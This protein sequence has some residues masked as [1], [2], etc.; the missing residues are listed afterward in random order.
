[1]DR[2]GFAHFEIDT[3]SET[4]LER[5]LSLIDLLAIGVG[6]TIG[7]GLFV[8]AGLV[9][10]EYAGPSSVVSWAI[11]G[12]AALLSGCCYA[13]LSARI[14]LSGGAYA[15]AF[16]AMGELPAVLT[17]ACLSLEYLAAASA[18]ARSWGDKVVEWLTEMLGD[19]HAAVNFLGSSS[20][21]FSPLAFLISSGTVVL[22]LNGVKESKKATNFFTTLKVSLV[23]FMVLL[24]F[25]HVQPSNWVPFVPP[26]FGYSGILRGATGEV[27]QCSSDMCHANPSHQFVKGH[28]S[29][30]WDTTKSLAWEGKPS[31]QNGIFLLLSY[32]P[33]WEYRSR[34]CWLHSHSLECKTIRRS[35]QSLVFL[36]RFTPWIS[37]SPDKSRLSE[38]S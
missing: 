23:V 28:F 6:G 9:A 26:Q 24:G 8:L 37:M 27:D 5:H 38:K 36:L 19:G 15:Y 14:P 13:E 11:S 33:L 10:H 17:A 1:V 34:T 12:C 35:R 3:G 4:A 7:S 20:A 18:V 2:P 30:T 22:L 16:V 25:L 21:S 31:I 32:S 29:A